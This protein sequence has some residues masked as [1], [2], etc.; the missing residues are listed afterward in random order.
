[1]LCYLQK[2]PAPKKAFT[3]R[4]SKLTPPV[5]Y[6]KPARINTQSSSANTGSVYIAFISRIQAAL[7]SKALLTW[8]Q[9]DKQICIHCTVFFRLLAKSQHKT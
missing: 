4:T 2:L 3:I 1:M 9:T 6:F 5:A 7:A 8:V